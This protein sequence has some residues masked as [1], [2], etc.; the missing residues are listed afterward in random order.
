MRLTVL[1]GAAAGGNTGQGCSGY[2]VES[3]STRVV[4]DLGPGTLPELRRHVDYRALAGVVV[5][6][7][8][9][10][11]VLD[12]L[13]LRFALAYNPRPAPRPLQLWMPP[14][15]LAFLSGAAAAFAAPGEEERFF[16]EQFDVSEYDPSRPLRIGGLSI[17]FAPTTHFVPCWATRV[18]GGDGAVLTYTADT[19]PAADLA[20]FAAG[21]GV[22]VAEANDV[23]PTPDRPENRGHMTA[24]EAGDLA[25]RAGAGRLVLAHLWEE[26]GL[27]LSRAQAARAFPG[28]IEIARPGLRLSW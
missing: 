1:G 12:L 6:H 24:A 4:L 10:D 5:S 23:D 8:H 20:A 2:L 9:L 19:G 7:V 11:H 27:P 28:P 14:G 25:R 16:A 3:G 18:E 26:N 21:S 17:A 13:A 15:G 22:L